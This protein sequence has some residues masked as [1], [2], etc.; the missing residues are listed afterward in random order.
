MN[1]NRIHIIFVIPELNIMIK[2]ILFYTCSIAV[3]AF[4][5][6]TNKNKLDQAKLIPKDASL[7]MV[8]NTPSMEEKIKSDAFL[9]MD[10]VMKSVITKEDSI[11]IKKQFGKLKDAIDLKEKF[12]FFMTQK[13]KGKTPVININI[14]A[15]LKDAKTFESAIKENEDW[16]NITI[17][18]TET[19]SYFLPDNKYAIS[20]NDKFVMLSINPE[21]DGYSFDNT[22]GSFGMTKADTVLFIKQIT[23]YFTLAE[24]ESLAS[25]KPF[26]DLI[27]ENADVYSFSNTTYLTSYLSLMPIQLVKLDS[28]VRDNYSTGTISFVN[29]KVESNGTM[30]LNKG[31]AELLKKYS[32][33]SVQTNMLDAYPTQDIN[34]FV[35][36]S[37]NPAVI[38]GLLKELDVETLADGYLQKAGMSTKDI[39]QSLKGDINVAFSDFKM[40]NNPQ[41]FGTTSSAKYL[42]EATIADKENFH[43]LMDLLLPT[44]KIIKVGN[45]Y[46]LSPDLAGYAFLHTDDQHLVIATDAGVYKEYVSGK[47]K[48]NIPEDIKSAVKGKSFA[49]YLNI[50]NFLSGL[51]ILSAKDTMIKNNIQRVRNTIKDAIVTTDNL[52][53]GEIKSHGELRL[54]DNKQNSLIQLNNMIM[55]MVKSVSTSIKKPNHAV[56]TDSTL[57]APV[58]AD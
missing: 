31:L 5:S 25:V 53:D 54:K 7:V 41:G 32:G 45:G 49:M 38:G 24:N 58:T 56:V 2:K 44:G 47:S 6:C 28:L 21:K 12:V 1:L 40:V 29:G 19:F 39:Y 46:T 27:H 18:K 26:V 11:K 33:N 52:K 14:I 36:A 9:K 51:D 20:W 34:G 10:S 35:L 17:K 23:K 42:V 48:N 57:T 8:I 30:Y 50:D 37:F 55:E 43:K 22:T 4:A 3:I 15:V 16:K 13:L